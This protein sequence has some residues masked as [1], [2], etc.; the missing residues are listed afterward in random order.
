MNISIGTQQFNNHTSWDTRPKSH[1]LLDIN[2]FA[3]HFRINYDLDLETA[4][5]LALGLY[6]FGETLFNARH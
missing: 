6:D 3:Y 2:V 4:E 1:C 5:F